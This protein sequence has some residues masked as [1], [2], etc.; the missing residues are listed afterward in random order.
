MFVPYYN[1]GLTEEGKYRGTY[2]APRW[3]DEIPIREKGASIEKRGRIYSLWS[4]AVSNESN[5]L[6]GSVSFLR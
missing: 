6:G 3:S 1:L 5:I 2:N 4:F